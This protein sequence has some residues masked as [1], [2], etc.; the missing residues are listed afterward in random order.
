MLH[1]VV[2]AED[3]VHDD[4]YEAHAAIKVATTKQVRPIAAYNNPMEQP[5][6]QTHLSRE[7]MRRTNG[8]SSRSSRL[9]SIRLEMGQVTVK[10]V[11]WISLAHQK[12][13][14]TGT[15]RLGWVSRLLFAWSMAPLLRALL[16]DRTRLS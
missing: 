10:C 8:N 4:A 6:K 5:C 16:A 13:G 7:I 3:Q 12:H 15:T 1:V 9:D 2:G 14:R 11:W